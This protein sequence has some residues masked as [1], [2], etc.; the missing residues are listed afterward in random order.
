[1][2]D[3]RVGRPVLVEGEVATAAARGVSFFAFLAVV[4]LATGVVLL[5]AFVVA[6]DDVVASVAVKKV[7]I[8]ETWLKRG[9]KV[10]HLSL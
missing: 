4:T 1:M 9:F 7:M 3:A 2:R 10:N 6:V 5:E 8:H